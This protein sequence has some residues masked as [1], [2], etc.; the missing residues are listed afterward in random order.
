MWVARGSLCFLGALSQLFG[1]KAWWSCLLLVLRGAL[2]L[3]L[4]LGQKWSLWGCESSIS[5]GLLSLAVKQ[6][7]GARVAKGPIF[8]GLGGHLRLW[9]QIAA[10]RPFLLAVLF[11]SPCNAVLGEGTAL[12]RAVCGRS[13]WISAVTSLYLFSHF[14]LVSDLQGRAQP[15]RQTIFPHPNHHPRPSGALSSCTN[16]WSP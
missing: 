14:S 16:V 4:M 5:L 12:V 11:A 13:F 8:G 9:C 15:Q 6:K 10:Q 7:I 1:A 3:W 2:V